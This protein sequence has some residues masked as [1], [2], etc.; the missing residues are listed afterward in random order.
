M[1]EEFKYCP[2]ERRFTADR[3]GKTTEEILLSRTGQ[4]TNTKERVF[5]NVMDRQ[6][7][8]LG[9]G[10]GGLTVPTESVR[11]GIASYSDQIEQSSLFPDRQSRVGGD[12]EAQRLAHE[13]NL[14]QHYAEMAGGGNAARQRNKIRNTNSWRIGD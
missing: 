2:G 3:M 8:G 12:R 10:R 13:R 5:G 11:T 14:K 4:E 7:Q 9:S 6:A 1:G